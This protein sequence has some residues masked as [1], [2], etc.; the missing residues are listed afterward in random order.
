MLVR[1]SSNGFELVR[2]KR[3][4]SPAASAVKPASAAIPPVDG[5]GT[6]DRAETVTLRLPSLFSED[7]TESATARK[8]RVAPVRPPP[9]KKIWFKRGERL[10]KLLAPVK[11][12]LAGPPGP[13]GTLPLRKTPMS[14][15]E[16]PL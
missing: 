2:P 6:E 14:A 8:R 16:G 9:M 12:S 10:V 4:L 1:L 5:S 13:L 7:P 11:S 15:S 3:L